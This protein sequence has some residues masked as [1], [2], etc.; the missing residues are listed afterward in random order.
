MLRKELFFEKT[1]DYSKIFYPIRCK[2]CATFDF[3]DVWSSLIRI[4]FF[5][6]EH[7]P[8]D[9]PVEICAACHREVEEEEE[10]FVKSIYID[11]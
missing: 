1:I 11:Q 6:D 4:S 8:R 7:Y 2:S 3:T 9:K 5:T 10:D